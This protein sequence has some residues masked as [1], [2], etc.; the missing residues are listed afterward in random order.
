MSPSIV[1]SSE[2]ASLQ[3][4]EIHT[5]YHQ[6]RAR[7]PVLDDILPNTSSRKASVITTVRNPSSLDDLRVKHS[8]DHPLIT[9]LDVTQPRETQ[10]A[11]AQAKAGFGRVDVVVNNAGFADIGEVEGIS[12][13][14]ARALFKT[15]FRGTANVSREAVR[16]SRDENAPGIGGRLLQISSM[17]GVAGW[18]VW[19]YFSVTKFAL[20]GP[21]EAL[22]SELDP[23]WNIRVS[24]YIESGA[25]G[26]AA[27]VKNTV[28]ATHPAYSHPDLPVSHFRQQWKSAEFSLPGGGTLLRGCRPTESPTKDAVTVVRE[29]AARLTADSADKFRYLSQNYSLTDN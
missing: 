11:F 29:K 8:I 24:N 22:A 9:K 12:D 17:L 20:E 25:F 18:L 5:H 14:D 15:N 16:F 23:A 6:S 3:I 28:T 27:P 10:D 1:W 21:T 2:P 4:F 19:G 26:I 13:A 7:L